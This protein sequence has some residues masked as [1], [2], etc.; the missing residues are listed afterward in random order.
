VIV[1]V[2]GGA[3]MLAACGGGGGTKVGPTTSIAPPSTTAIPSS[4]TTLPGPT[5]PEGLARGLFDAWKAGDRGAAARFGT[6][7]AVNEVF[8]R[9]FKQIQTSGGPTDQ[10][11]FKACQVQASGS[12]GVCTFTAQ[13][14]ELD[15]TIGVP[16]PGQ[17]LVVVSVKFQDTPTH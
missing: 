11:K 17:P 14:S 5:N 10:Y 2:A 12:A 9:P 6:P 13:D 1:A 15:M 8:A 4:S 3:L 7:S 16:S